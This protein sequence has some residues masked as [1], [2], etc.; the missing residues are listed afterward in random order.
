MR[1]NRAGAE[2]LPRCDVL[3]LD[4]SL[5][6]TE[7]MRVLEQ[8]RTLERWRDTPTIVMVTPYDHD[9]LAGEQFA[10]LRTSL[11]LKPVTSSN[12]FDAITEHLRPPS[13]IPA[14][15]Q[16]SGADALRL[17]GVSV[18]LVEDNELNQVVA[19]GLLQSAGA[20]VSLAI[21]GRDAVA[22][23]TSREHGFDVVL[24]DVH[25][26]VMDGMT[27]TRQ[28]RQQ[29]HDTVPII[30][31]TAAVMVDEQESYFK[32]GMNDFVAKPVEAN[33]MIAAIKR[34]I[35]EANGAQMMQEGRVSGRRDGGDAQPFFHDQARRHEAY[36]RRIGRRSGRGLTQYGA[37]ELGPSRRSHS[38]MA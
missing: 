31:M 5:V 14:I 10:K 15:E 22:R 4:W 20:H 36:G 28:I 33:L 11:L 37:N 12:L 6:G 38:A 18:L 8:M 30:A 17:D 1:C 35:S 2:S 13:S 16:R 34:Q 21:N 24:M 25:M 32:V 3:L 29:L 26:P 27:A 19:R 23:L 7:G 9:H